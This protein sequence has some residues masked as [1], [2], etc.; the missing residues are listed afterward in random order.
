[1]EWIVDKKKWKPGMDKEFIETG[2]S[3]WPCYPILPIKRKKDNMPMGVEEGIICSGNKTLV[4]LT[5]I[6]II[7]PNAETIKYGSVDEMLADGWM[8]Y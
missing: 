7:N 2:E 5:N 3:D 6:F 1:M 8:V 4:V